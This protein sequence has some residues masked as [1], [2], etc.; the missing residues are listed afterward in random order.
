MRSI[1]A[2]HPDYEQLND[3]SQKLAWTVNPQM[4]WE[5]R[6]VDRN[7]PEHKATV[8]ILKAELKR[9][10]LGGAFHDFINDAKTLRNMNDL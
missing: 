2:S 6:D 9:E 8:F 10:L 4:L 5:G 7:T 1:F 3:L